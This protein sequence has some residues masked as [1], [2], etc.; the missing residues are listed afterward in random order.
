MGLFGLE[1]C[2]REK[3][4]SWVQKGRQ[5]PKEMGCCNHGKE[6]RQCSGHKKPQEDADPPQNGLCFT[7]RA[8]N[9]FEKLDVRGEGRRRI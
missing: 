9:L 7:L 6:S 1:T 2:L 3:G 4:G 8:D 5:S